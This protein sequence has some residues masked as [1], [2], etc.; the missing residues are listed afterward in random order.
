MEEI[1]VKSEAKLNN[2][3]SSVLCMKLN[4]ERQTAF[5]LILTNTYAMFI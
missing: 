2:F 5:I 3:H 1:Q 4:L